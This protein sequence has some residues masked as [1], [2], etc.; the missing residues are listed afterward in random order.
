[1]FFLSVLYANKLSRDSFHLWLLR[2]YHVCPIMQAR[3][4]LSTMLTECWCA[5][6]AGNEVFLCIA[7]VL[8]QCVHHCT[9]CYKVR[10]N[11]SLLRVIF[12]FTK[13][14]GPPMGPSQLPVQWALGFLP[15]EWSGRGV[16]FYTRGRLD[17]I[18]NLFICLFTIY[19][20]EQ[21]QLFH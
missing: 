7:G 17:E 6:C 10:R 8:K 4:D 9:G 11:I 18:I 5:T 1:M 20:Y 2:S 13:M 14:S 21:L 15:W 16:K 12:S 3:R 19:F